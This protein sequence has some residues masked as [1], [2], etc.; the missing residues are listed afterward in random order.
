MTDMWTQWT[1]RNVAE[2]EVVPL[3]M[4]WP[5]YLYEDHP[6]LDVFLLN[7]T[8]MEKGSS[9]WVKMFGVWWQPHGLTLCLLPEGWTH[10][11]VMF[12]VF[13]HVEKWLKGN[14]ENKYLEP[15]QNVLLLS[16]LPRLVLLSFK[17]YLGRRGQEGQEETLTL[18]RQ[19][20]TNGTSLMLLRVYN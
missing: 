13:N 1:D 9:Y 7:W 8:E 14:T 10:E 17:S 16:T 6:G 2:L 4:Q 3:S 15:T 11:H 12:T 20:V 5:W 19:E 18:L